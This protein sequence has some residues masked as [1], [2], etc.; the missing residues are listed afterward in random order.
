MSQKITAADIIALANA[1][2]T[3]DQIADI[4]KLRETEQDDPAPE[5]KASTDPY[6]QI[7]DRL[8]IIEQSIHKAALINSEQPKPDSVDEILARIINPDGTVPNK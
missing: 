4:G 1:G 6:M 3:A 5:V 8:G 2:Y 7:M